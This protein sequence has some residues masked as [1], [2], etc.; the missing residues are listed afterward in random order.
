M[1]KKT[2]S[3]ILLSLYKQIRE[4]TWLISQSVY[5]FYV[6]EIESTLNARLINNKF[7]GIQRSYTEVQKQPSHYGQT[8]LF[9]DF[10]ERN[11]I[12]EIKEKLSVSRSGNEATQERFPGNDE[13]DL[14]LVSYTIM[15]DFQ[16]ERTFYGGF[17]WDLDLL[18]NRIIPKILEDLSKD[19]GLDFKIV[20]E[21]D[22]NI[23]SG[24]DGLTSGE[25]LV[26]S[27]PYISLCPGSFLL[28]TLK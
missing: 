23:T 6:S 16:S 28:L 7:P 15:P 10:L 25:S 24:T 4:G 1:M 2:L 12:P 9:K 13:D 17:K 8:L 19:S 20:N 26:L 21:N 11:V 27:F 22:Q 3:G 5:D 18:R 14:F